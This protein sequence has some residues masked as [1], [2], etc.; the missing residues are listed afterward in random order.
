VQVSIGLPSID[1][2]HNY[3]SRKQWNVEDFWACDF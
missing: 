3:A 2:I 1:L